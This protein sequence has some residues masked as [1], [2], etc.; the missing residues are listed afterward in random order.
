LHLSL[1]DALDAFRATGDGWQSRMNEV[2]RANK[3]G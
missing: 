1:A 3:P 2:L